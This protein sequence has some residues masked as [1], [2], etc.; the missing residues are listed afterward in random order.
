MIA[1]YP[2][3][4][5]S[6]T[7]V[8]LNVSDEQAGDATLARD[9]EARLGEK[10]G[11]SFVEIPMRLEAEIARL[12]STEERAAFM[13]EMGIADTALHMLTARCIDALGLISF[14][15]VAPIEVRHWFV[16]RGSLAP[17]AAGVIHSD[18]ERGFIRAEVM[19]YPDIDALGSEEKVKA[20]GKYHVKGKDYV[21]QDGDMLFIR[22]SV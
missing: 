18:L 17:R 11:V 22:F 21:V 1:S 16:K 19:H 2:L 15:T 3:L 14:F 10:L 5:R 12:D 9:L 4:T 13:A 7:I 20:A 6:Q 8:A